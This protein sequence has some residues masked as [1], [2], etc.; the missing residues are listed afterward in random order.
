MTQSPGPV[1]QPYPPQPSQYP[2]SQPPARNGMGT[3]AAVCGAFSVLTIFTTWGALPFGIIAIILGVKG[4]RLFKRGEAT[5]GGAAR[6]GIWFGMLGIALTLI[7]IGVALWGMFKPDGLMPC[8]TSAGDDT[9]ATD[10]CQQQFH[11]DMPFF[12]NVPVPAG[13]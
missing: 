1:G 9:A 12:V 8:L 11:D 3:W 10:Q 7:I 5:N 6:T 2:P 4:R 13:G